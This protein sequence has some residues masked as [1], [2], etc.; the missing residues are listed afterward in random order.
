[1]SGTMGRG[2]RVPSMNATSADGGAGVRKDPAVDA[3]KKGAPV[4]GVCVAEESFG[5]V[6]APADSPDVVVRMGGREPNAESLRLALAEVPDFSPSV[7]HPLTW[8]QEV[9]RV[10]N[11]CGLTEREL[12]DVVMRRSAVCASV[13]DDYGGSGSEALSLARIVRG[14]YG[15][16]GALTPA[17]P[18]WR[19]LRALLCRYMAPLP[20]LRV[21]L[22]E[23]LRGFRQEAGETAM[24]AVVRAERLLR[25]AESAECGV[26]EDE[27]ALTV[28]DSLELPADALRD[29]L[30]V[31]GVT[32]VF[33]LAHLRRAVARLVGLDPRAAR[34]GSL[35]AGAHA[36]DAVDRAAAAHGARRA[37]AVDA[38]D[39][40][41][42]AREAR[43][44]N[45]VDAVDR[46]AAARGAR[47]ASAE[48]PR[49]PTTQG[50]GSVAAQPQAAPAIAA[51]AGH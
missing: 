35:G 30:I 21:M 10:A 9:A 13:V 19:T 41:A 16:A 48:G 46:A 34:L 43:R 37:N 49:G 12:G 24:E 2:L 51:P 39:R 3:P 28:R 36:V 25:L 27:L 11:Q 5:G 18:A 26:A 20:E 40:A 17:T 6:C 32:R 4:L 8:L 29:E 50:T 7:W 33:E 31:Q 23:H 15:Y 38:V 22:R 1:M 47:R 45:A 42:A 14:W 44:A